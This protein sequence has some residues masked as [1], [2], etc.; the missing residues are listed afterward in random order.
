LTKTGYFLECI[1]S[2]INNML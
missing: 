1:H 2:W